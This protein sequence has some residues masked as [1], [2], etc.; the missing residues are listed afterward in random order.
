VLNAL[1]LVKKSVG[2]R[3]HLHFTKRLLGGLRERRSL[4]PADSD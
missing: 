3:G 4:D 1:N 2:Q